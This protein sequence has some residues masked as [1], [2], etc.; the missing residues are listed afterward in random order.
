MVSQEFCFMN[1]LY[2]SEFKIQLA[3]SEQ[4]TTLKIQGP[5][6]LPI[7]QTKNF[8]HVIWAQLKN[9]WDVKFFSNIDVF[10]YTTLVEKSSR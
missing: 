1:C 5:D 4:F 6:H 7:E 2:R 9:K 10:I 3:D 8:I